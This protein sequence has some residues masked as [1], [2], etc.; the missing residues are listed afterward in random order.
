MSRRDELLALTNGFMEAF[1][2]NDLDRMMSY[3]APDGAVY[4]EFNGT[5]NQGVDAIRAAFAPQFDGAFGEMKF[6]DEDLFLDP[7]ADKVMVSWRCTLEVKGEPVGWRGLD[8]LHW[9]GDKVTQKIT[10]AKAKAPL[11]S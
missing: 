3:F 7:E 11:F 6:L 5:A 1:N 10:Y 4:D 8:L 2:E 9:D